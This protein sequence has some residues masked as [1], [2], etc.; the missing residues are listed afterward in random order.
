MSDS[1]T[2]SLRPN[3]SRYG[4]ASDFALE[5][6]EVT[7]KVY[8]IGVF[9]DRVTV[10]SQM[11]RAMNLAVA[12][13]N[14]RGAEIGRVAIV[15]G[16]MAG[17]TFASAL[18]MI[19][20]GSTIDLFERDTRLLPLQHGCTRRNLHPHIYNWP[21]EGSATPDAGLPLLNWSADKS[22]VVAE[23][24]LAQ[25]EEIRARNQN[26]RVRLGQDVV[27]TKELSDAVQLTVVDLAGV[28]T[29]GNYS[30]V[31]LAVGFGRERQEFSGVSTA[32]YWSDAGVPERAKASKGVFSVLV[33]GDGDGGL[34]DFCAACLDDFDHS[35]LIRLVSE[36][37][38]LD[39]LKAR[40][41]AIDDE[42][43]RKGTTANLLEAY[44]KQISRPLASSGL[45]DEIE[46]QVSMRH[47]VTLH[48]RVAEAFRLNTA[49]LNRFTAFILLHL[50]RTR[51]RNRFRHI[52]GPLQFVGYEPAVE[53]AST[54]RMRFTVSG[55]PVV[56]DSAFLRHGTTRE[57]SFTGFE[58]MAKQ[59]RHRYTAWLSTHRRNREPPELSSQ[60]AQL[61]SQIGLS[62]KA[63]V[64]LDGRQMA[65]PIGACCV[66]ACRLPASNVFRMD[67][68]EALPV[69][70]T[71]Y[72]AAE[73]GEMSLSIL[74][75]VRDFLVVRPFKSTRMLETRVELLDS[76][77]ELTI[78]SQGRDMRLNLVGPLLLHPDWYHARRDEREKPAANMDS[79]LFTALS[80]R[81]GSE[82]HDVKLLFRNVD[83]YKAKVSETVTSTKERKKLV[84]EMLDNLDRIWPDEA[85]G[86]PDLVC[87]ETG[88]HRHPFIYQ[89]A[90]IDVVRMRPDSPTSSG[91]YYSDAG[92]VSS[93]RELFDKLFEEYSKSRRQE[94]RKLRRFIISLKDS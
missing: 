76:L 11:I 51:L 10:R 58:E 5:Q 68:S 15:G 78:R 60:A 56:V 62:G 86:G 73:A 41:L 45:L 13:R 24:I 21:A 88:F 39:E 37:P 85:A 33:S 92:Y 19:S 61:L 82:Y 47:S 69:C 40:L 94:F 46:S 50:G 66:P 89:S 38:G 29:S 49:I 28:K 36:F 72:Q 14:A 43:L 44:R 70:R 25:F 7:T 75:A 27:A 52:H 91:V 42:A 8:A 53:V 79:V 67:A 80:S 16:G 1:N 22:S 87:L 81:S 3:L 17:V 64:I 31:V 59:Y 12:L 63:D 74:K 20:P 55:A 9:A 4:D 48:T 71:H 35:R 57:Y 23:S 18:G 77:A 93:Q 65:Y 2:P 83:R 32:S 26:I 30:C 84:D 54:H 90:M 6:F 34:I